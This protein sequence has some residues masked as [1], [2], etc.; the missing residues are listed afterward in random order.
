MVKNISS[1]TELSDLY[2]KLT[3]RSVYDHNNLLKILAIKK[4]DQMKLC[5]SS[6][7]ITI[8]IECFVES[9]FDEIQIRKINN[10]PYSEGHIWILL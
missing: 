2:Q 9:L 6:S 1:N 10:K 3:E 5:S 8:V 7:S 4:H